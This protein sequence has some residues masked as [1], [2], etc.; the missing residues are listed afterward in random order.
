MP[1]S[2]FRKGLYALGEAYNRQIDDDTVRLWAYAAREMTDDQF[3]YGVDV[4]IRSTNRFFPPPGVVIEAG[5]QGPP[6]P[7]AKAHAIREDGF[8]ESDAQREHVEAVVH[9]TPRGPSESAMAY[10]RRLAI[11]SG[12]IQADP[13]EIVFDFPAAGPAPD[14]RETPEVPEEEDEE[15]KV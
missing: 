5:Y 6:P 11:K 12:L 9:V 4:V 8:W 15:V 1:D 3:R 10:I 2:P 13:G 14:V 7:R